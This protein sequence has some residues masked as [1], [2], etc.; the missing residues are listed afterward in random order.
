MAVGSVHF[1][2]EDVHVRGGVV[3]FGWAYQGSVVER[4]V[5]VPVPIPTRTMRPRDMLEITLPSTGDHER[6][7]KDHAGCVP[8]T[9]ADATR[10][11]TALM[12]TVFD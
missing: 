5:S 9:D 2:R 3:W 4:V 11:T 1:I 6:R 8:V 12:M 7:P 10:W